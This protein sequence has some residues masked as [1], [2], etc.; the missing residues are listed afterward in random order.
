MAK[1]P[2]R[3]AKEHKSHAL[4]LRTYARNL[5]L[6]AAR[7]QVQKDDQAYNREVG[8]TGKERDNALRKSFGSKYREIKRRIQAGTFMV[9]FRRDFDG[10]YVHSIGEN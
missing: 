7:I 6:K 8:H 5:P 2:K 4:R 9:E 3:A 10:V 1:L